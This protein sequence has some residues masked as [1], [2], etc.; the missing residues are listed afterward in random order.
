[1]RKNSGTYLLVPLCALIIL[2][3]PAGTIAQEM[4]SNTFNRIYAS[5]RHNQSET[6]FISL[7]DA[8]NQLKSF[9]KVKV[10]YK[11]GLLD[12][13]T[14]Q[15]GVTGSFKILDVEAALKQL[16]SN[17]T[18]TYKKIGE[19]QFS[20]FEARST[21]DLPAT[22]PTAFSIPVTGKVASKSGE[23]LPKVTISV[24]SSPDIATVSDE[25]G[26]FKLSVPDEMKG[27]SITLV[28][29]SIG[30][31]TKELV[32]TD[33]QQSVSVQLEES[34]KEL[35]EVVVTALGIKKTSKSL[36]YSTTEIKGSEFTQA[37]ENN[38][39]NALSG[40]VAGVNATGISTGP[41]GSSRVVIRGNGSLTGN[42][43]PSI[44][45]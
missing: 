5:Q 4:A 33:L 25:N 44:C 28:I 19:N 24:K 8:V 45:N 42:S 15:A 38:V 30:Y 29:S 37:R 35:G 27:K 9:Y 20:I 31:T 43:Q 34:N 18:L 11:E 21:N 22:E 12:S 36:T 1:M 26:N 16:F 17:T 6:M 41:G 40:K 23:G 39:A 32:I 14:V 7:K 10:A 13:R 3:L 2:G